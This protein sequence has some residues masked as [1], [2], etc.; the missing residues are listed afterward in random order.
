MHKII[1]TIITALVFSYGYE[2]NCL[3]A[4]WYSRND[5]SIKLDSV[6]FY[7]INSGVINDWGWK[8]TYDNKQMANLISDS[9]DGDGPET[10][11][12]YSSISEIPTNG[13][14]LY[15][16]V[17]IDGDTLIS[18]SRTY[19]DGIEDT[20]TVTKMSA[21]MQISKFESSYFNFSDTIIF[22]NDS[23]IVFDHGTYRDSTV[24]EYIVKSTDLICNVYN[25]KNEIK[26]SIVL[27]NNV[28]GYVYVIEEGQDPRRF[29]YFIED[30]H[31]IIKDSITKKYKINPNILMKRYDLNGRHVRHKY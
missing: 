8:Y 10:T 11:L 30:N 12:V 29:N 19:V 24:H 2:S 15:Q 6:Y 3:N 1:V 26:D 21:S 7:E 5:S 17:T 27:K 13:L 20:K 16:K 18:E 31:T 14:A 22:R 28:P 23:I 9:Y 25:E 4:Y